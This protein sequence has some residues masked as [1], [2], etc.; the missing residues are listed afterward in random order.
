M[1]E[2]WDLYDKDRNPLTAPTSGACP[3]PRGSTTWR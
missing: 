2:L 3:W 1:A